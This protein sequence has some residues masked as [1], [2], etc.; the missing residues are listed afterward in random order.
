MPGLSR[1]RHGRCLMV[2]FCDFILRA[3]LS[4]SLPIH[5]GVWG[6][7]HGSSREISCTCIARTTTSNAPR[8]CVLSGKNVWLPLKIF[9]Q[10]YPFSLSLVE[11]FSL[12]K[13]RGERTNPI[14]LRE[15]VCSFFLFY[16]LCCVCTFD[17]KSPDSLFFG[18]VNNRR[19]PSRWLGRQRCHQL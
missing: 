1:S 6:S 14:V 2:R 10:L 13:S 4:L 12:A 18:V 8:V 11:L 9:T 3:S 17:W 7:L 16:Y 15:C 19:S 5:V